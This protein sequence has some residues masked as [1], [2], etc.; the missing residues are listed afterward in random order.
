MALIMFVHYAV[1]SAVANRFAALNARGDRKALN[2]Y[3][4]DA[5]NCTFWTSL[6]CAPNILALSKPPLW[7]FGPQFT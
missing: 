1:G 5:V 3:V 6:L 4:R 2:A 7:L